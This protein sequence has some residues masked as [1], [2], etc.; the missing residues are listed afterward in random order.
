MAAT[1][2]SFIETAPE[3][4]RPVRAGVSCAR[5]SRAGSKWVGAG[6]HASG[7]EQ[8]HRLVMARMGGQAVIHC[9]LFNSLVSL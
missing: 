1:R 4:F 8:D 3:L 9:A 6:R 5:R 7:R 2:E